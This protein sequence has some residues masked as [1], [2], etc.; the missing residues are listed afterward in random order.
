[1]GSALLLH[2]MGSS[3]ETLWRVREWTERAGFGVTAPALLGH[4][5]RRPADAYRIGAYADDVLAHGDFDLVIGHSL[6]GS[7]AILAAATRP[8]WTS[9][10]LLIEPAI[11]LDAETI[12]LAR[13]AE[14]AELEWTEAELRE[15]QPRWDDRDVAAKLAAAAL[16]LP[17]AVARTFTEN[18]VWDLEPMAERL[19]V[20][21]LVIVGDPTTSY[22]IVDEGTRRRLTAANPRI[23]LVSV[24]RTGHSPHRDDPVA[25]RAIVE[26]WLSGTA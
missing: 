6:G 1:M 25:T 4:G 13:P 9:R 22:S 3:P 24:P 5:G 26:G 10:L 17:D 8:E 16:A 18:A 12:E 11:R 19:A 15:A 23:E 7:A 20:P 21:T 14:L 2:G